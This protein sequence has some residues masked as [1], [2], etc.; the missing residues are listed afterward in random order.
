MHVRA[1]WTMLAVATVSSLTTV[2]AVSVLHPT[3]VVAQQSQSSSAVTMYAYH[4]KDTDKDQGFIFF[5]AKSGDIWVYDNENVKEH[6]KVGTLGAN[7]T[8][9]KR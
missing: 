6:Y 7:L 2:A 3:D 5:D 8:K 1:L 4:R 9:V